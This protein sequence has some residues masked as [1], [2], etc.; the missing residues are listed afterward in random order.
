MAVQITPAPF[1]ILGPH[2]VSGSALNSGFAQPVWASQQSATANGTTTSTAT[3]ITAAITNFTTV[4]SGGL[5]AMPPA[6]PGTHIIVFNDAAT[7]T[8]T[9][10]GYLSTDTIDGSATTTLTVAHHAAVFCCMA[11]GIWISA[12]LGVAT[13]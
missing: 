2:L 9:F 11:A 12:L 8:L 4:A 5:A 6:V 7:N 13:S 10:Q 1:A 3:Q